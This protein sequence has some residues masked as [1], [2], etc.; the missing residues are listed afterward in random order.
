M[1][2]RRASRSFSKVGKQ[3]RCQLGHVGHGAIAEAFQ[4]QGVERLLEGPGHGNDNTG[5]P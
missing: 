3:L 1:R 2:A 5:L 4:V